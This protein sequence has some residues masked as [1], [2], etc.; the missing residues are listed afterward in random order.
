MALHDLIRVRPLYGSKKVSGRLEC[1][2]RT[3]EEVRL[4]LGVAGGRPLGEHA[5]SNR[6]KEAPRHAISILKPR[7]CINSSCFRELGV[8][9]RVAGKR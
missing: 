5:K 4:A 9:D 7:T 2:G 1:K 8:A 3:R 6:A